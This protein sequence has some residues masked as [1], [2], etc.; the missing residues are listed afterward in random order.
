MMTAALQ[1]QREPQAVHI[2]GNAPVA[3]RTA[4][5]LSSHQALDEGALMATVGGN[6][7]RLRKQHRLSLESLS[8][9]CGVSRAMLGQLE[10]GKSMPS[11]KTLWQVAQALGVSVTWF[12]E[13]AHH[14]V[15]IPVPPESRVSLKSGEGELRSLQ[16]LGDSGVDAFYELRLARGAEI[17]LPAALSPQRIHVTSVQGVLTTLVDDTPHTLLPREALQYEGSQPMVWRNE[18]DMPV[19]AYVVVRAMGGPKPIDTE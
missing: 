1:G 15:H 6:L 3:S 18:A 12:L 17:R 7:R 19:Q 14:V 2:L 10:Q 8:A 4:H 11:I 16:H 5:T 9:L 13:A